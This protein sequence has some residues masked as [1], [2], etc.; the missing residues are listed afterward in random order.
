VFKARPARSFTEA[1]TALRAGGLLAP[2]P[3]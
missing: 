1:Q 2:S 3:L